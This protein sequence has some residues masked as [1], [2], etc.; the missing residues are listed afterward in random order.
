MEFDPKTTRNPSYR[1]LMGLGEEEGLVSGS[2]RF[3]QGFRSL[4]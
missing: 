4:C 3:F 1:V 2:H